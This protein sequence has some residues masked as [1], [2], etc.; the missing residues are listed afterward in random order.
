MKTNKIL[1][2]LQKPQ[3]VAHK[4]QEQIFKDNRTRREKMLMQLDKKKKY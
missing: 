1:P 3:K 2:F 4:N